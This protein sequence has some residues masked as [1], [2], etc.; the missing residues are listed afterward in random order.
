MQELYG[1]DVNNDYD[2]VYMEKINRIFVWVGGKFKYTIIV[3]K[4]G[5][6]MACDCPGNV[7]HGHCKHVDFVT[8]FFNFEKTFK[9]RNLIKKLNEEYITEWYLLKEE[10]WHGRNR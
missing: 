6:S 3:L 1:M 7:Y 2:M 4:K 10:G 8:G 5:K 9:P